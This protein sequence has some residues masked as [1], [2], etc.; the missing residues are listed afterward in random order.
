MLA[1]TFALLT[2]LTAVMTYPQV[3]VMR[4]GVA[5]VGDPLLNTWAL[6]WVAH[7]APIA[8]AR[9]FDGNV[10][11]PER[12]TLAYSEPMLVPALLAAPLHWLGAGPILVYNLVLLGALVASGLGTALLVLELTGQA[13]AAI[14]A[15]IIFAFLPFR[16]DHYS[17]L[18]LQQTQWIPLTMWALHRMVN[19]GRLADGARLGLFAACQML[20]CVYFGVFLAP[21]LAAAAL[22]LVAAHVRV[23]RSGPDV[24][25]ACN[26]EFARRTVMAVAV[27]AVVYGVLVAP[28][29]R[30]HMLAS[31]VVGERGKNEAVS[32]S[33]TLSDYLGASPSNRTYGRLAER[34]GHPERRL[35]PGLTAV[36]LAIVGLWR[37]WTASKAAYVAGLLVAFDL[38]LGFN[39]LTYPILWNV[40]TPLRGL[41]VPARMGLFVGFSLAVLAGYGVARLASVIRSVAA[42]R[43]V[44]AAL[45]AVILIECSSLPFNITA[46]ATTAP[47]V[48]QDMQRARGDA[49]RAAIVELPL[50]QGPTYMYYSTF[51]WQNLLNGYSGF[52]P[53]SFHTLEVAM[54]TFPDPESLRLLRSRETRFVLIHGEMMPR[55]EYDALIA[56][57]SARPA[58]Q[59]IARRPWRESE[60]SLY[61]LL[62]D[63][64]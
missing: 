48:Y 17:H 57:A 21:Y 19:G 14:V 16:F 2:A 60:I 55:D 42:Q 36:L 53:P 44:T 26:G 51:H 49:P 13:S 43:L 58:L 46:M 22:V 52:F 34:F 25:L 62:P 64:T 9:I 10:F 35:F 32:G 6:A 29:G 33:A 24:L 37:P 12:W 11:Y 50:G 7:Q 20:S 40:A 63:G 59:L 15:G 8:P 54:A 38:S 18:Q 28:V 56:A 5:D 4:T 39:G 3:L 27:A 45:A 41:R 47:E 30:A 23:E 61:R 1:F 31:Q